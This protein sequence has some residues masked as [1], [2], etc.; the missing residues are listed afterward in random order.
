[1][2]ADTY[3]FTADVWLRPGEAGWH[4]VTLPVE[5]ADELRAQTAET[6]RPFGSLPVQV[7]IGR[8]SWATSLFPDTSAASYLLPIKADIRRREQ[9]TAGDAV[10]VSLELVP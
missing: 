2:P 9:L 7:T 3:T 5:L 10:R 4:F 6:A 1:M 8:T